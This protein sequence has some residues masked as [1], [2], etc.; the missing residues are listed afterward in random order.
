LVVEARILPHF[1]PLLQRGFLLEACVGC[2]IATFLRDRCRLSPETIAKRI[3]TVFLDGQP[4]DDVD[5]AFVEHNSTLA[6]SGAMPGLAGAVMRSKSPL[7]SFRSSITHSGEGSQG[8]QRSGMVRLKLFNT[9]MSELGH[10]MLRGGVLLDTAVVRDFL[11][12]Q[13]DATLRQFSE[14]LIDGRPT[15]VRTILELDLLYDSD[16]VMLTVD[17]Q[18]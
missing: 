10:P 11:A 3:S 2:S 18:K 14:V 6:L 9:V 7:R 4:V 8:A 17:V 1:F 13:T 5:H 16:L 12:K 15:N